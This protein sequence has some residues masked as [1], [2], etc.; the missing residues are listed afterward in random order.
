MDK[1]NGVKR[2]SFIMAKYCVTSVIFALFLLAIVNH[3]F[4]GLK[5][6]AVAQSDI[7]IL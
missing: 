6:L 2:N 7:Y 4:G 1:F 5:K 3:V